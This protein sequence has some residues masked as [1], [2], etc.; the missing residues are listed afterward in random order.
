MEAHGCN[1]LS[2]WSR[3]TRDPQ[4]AP[5]GAVETQV[6]STFT[7]EFLPTVGVIAIMR[8]QVSATLPIGNRMQEAVLRKMSKQTCTLERRIP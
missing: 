3:R 8:S 1:T 7:P 4:P 2:R 6:H 5:A